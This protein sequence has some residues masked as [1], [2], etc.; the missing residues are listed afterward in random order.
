MLVKFIVMATEDEALQGL[1]DFRNNL[2]DN[3]GKSNAGAN[4]LISRTTAEGI[5]ETYSSINDQMHALK[6]SLEIEEIIEAKKNKNTIR[7]F[8]TTRN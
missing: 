6:Q 3:L 8:K 5:S 2:A 4:R 7:F 1:E